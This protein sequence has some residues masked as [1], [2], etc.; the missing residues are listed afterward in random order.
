M[1]VS[2]LKDVSSKTPEETTAAK[3]IGEIGAGTYAAEILEIRTHYQKVL[4]ETGDKEKAKKAVD[5]LKKRLPAV[6]WSGV[7]SGR[8]DKNLKSYS[9]LLCADLDE[10]SDSV[11]EQTLAALKNDPHCLTAFVS[12]TG[13]GIKAVFPVTPEAK[14]HPRN[15]ETVKVHVKKSLNLDVDPKCKNVERLCFVSDG[16]AHVNL[17]ALPL[18]LL[19]EE[20]NSNKAPSRPSL[21]PVLSLSR[22]G[23][24]Q[25]LLGRIEWENDVTGYA[26]CPGKHLHTAENGERDFKVMLEGVPTVTCFH[27]SCHGLVA[28]TN[29]ELRSQIGKAE[30]VSTENSNLTAQSDCANNAPASDGWKRYIEEWTVERLREPI[31]YEQNLAGARWLERGG[32][33]ALVAPSGIGKTVASVQIAVS[34]SVGHPAFHIKPACALRVLVVQNEDTENDTKG[35]LQGVIQNCGFDS[36]AV[37]LMNANLKIVRLVALRGGMA[38]K[39]IRGF[40]IEWKADVIM[41]NPLMAYVPGKQ[42]EETEVFIREHLQPIATE[43]KVG[44]VAIHHTPKIGRQNGVGTGGNEYERQYNSAGKAEVVNA[45][46]AILNIMPIGNGV[47]KFTADKR[48]RKIG[49]TWE[50]KPTIERYFKHACDPVNPDLIWWKDATPEEAEQ[51][52][53]GEMYQDILK[54]LPDYDESAVSRERVHEQAKRILKIGKHKADGWLKLAIEDKLVDRVENKNANGRIEVLFRRAKAV[55]GVYQ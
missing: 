37:A 12:P 4:T 6:Q 51:A 50:G 28:A 55:E 46:R 27:Q 26:C 42:G 53:N 31:D 38:A 41:V 15:F 19:A 33:A 29:H 24:A 13:T 54:I 21:S 49:W 9:G 35:P 32:T 8:G 45:F 14:N 17:R 1:N 23:I 5:G 34:W 47:F 2:F 25:K 18:P 20:L 16:I 36:D 22:Q 44:I 11:I 43:L 40:A 39:A 3:V 48:G 30:S 7:F 10:L 52:A